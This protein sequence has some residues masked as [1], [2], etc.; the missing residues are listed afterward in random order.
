M[1][2]Y[3]AL[4]NATRSDSSWGV[5]TSPKRISL[6]RTA[7]NSLG[8]QRLYWMMR[9]Y[10]YGRA[11]QPERARC[12]LE[13][14]SSHEAVNPVTMFWAHLGAGNKQEARADVDKAYSESTSA[15]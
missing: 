7:S 4:K 10:I 2:G 14:L 9:A 13:K 15:F 1:E 8:A 12:E 5:R 3:R 6:K 11:G